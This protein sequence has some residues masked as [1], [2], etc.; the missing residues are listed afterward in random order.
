[1]L[2]EHLLGR[3][4]KMLNW[5]RNKGVLI[6]DREATILYLHITLQMNESSLMGIIYL[7][8]DLG[9]YLALPQ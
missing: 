6:E 4:T 9:T 2:R 3:I 5:N 7:W 8:V 1:M